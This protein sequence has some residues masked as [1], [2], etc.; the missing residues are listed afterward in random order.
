M[1]NTTH[2]Q[3]RRDAIKAAMNAVLKL[4][5]ITEFNYLEH[6]CNCGLEYLDI[7]CQDSPEV[8]EEI[9]SSPLFWNWWKNQW[10][11]RDEDFASSKIADVSLR[12][13]LRIWEEYHNAQLL[14]SPKTE[15]GKFMD[16]SYAHLI[17]LII[18]QTVK[19]K[20]YASNV[21]ST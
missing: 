8:F 13:R 15:G 5:G 3:S 10:M 18:K 2:I 12:Y 14:S 20:D 17:G 11:I 21:R 7:L 4:I 16:E 19:P 1:K 9:S 6:Q